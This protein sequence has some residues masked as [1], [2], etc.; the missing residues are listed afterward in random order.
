M[1]SSRLTLVTV[2]CVVFF[3]QK[4]IS[5]VDVERRGR[6]TECIVIYS[7][8]VVDFYTIIVWYRNSSQEHQ[9]A[10]ELRTDGTTRYSAVL[11]KHR[12]TWDLLIQ[13]ITE[14]DLGLY[15]CAVRTSDGK[16]NYGHRTTRLSLIDPGSDI[17]HP[18]YTSTPPVPECGVCCNSTPPVPECGVCWTLLITVCPVCVLLSSTCVYCLCFKRNLVLNPEIRDQHTEPDNKAG[19]EVCYSSIHFSKDGQKHP[20]KKRV[21]N[22]DFSTY[23]EVR[24]AE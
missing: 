17:P 15:Y 13:N 11:D 5:G 3:S 6:R 22:S 9:S 20:K 24:T 1:G 18:T 19:D 2:M 16:I 21:Q 12:N 14:S 7:D 23:A 4:R 10:V 8:C